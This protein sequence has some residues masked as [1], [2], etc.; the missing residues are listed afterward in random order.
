MIF[1]CSQPFYATTASSTSN[2]FH[3]LDFLQVFELGRSGMQS[4]VSP[5]NSIQSA[6]ILP[7]IPLALRSS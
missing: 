7:L 2:N 6:A 3:Q 5:L 4:S 1:R